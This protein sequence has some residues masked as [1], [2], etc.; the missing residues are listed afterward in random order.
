MVIQEKYNNQIRGTVGMMAASV[1][2]GLFAY[3]LVAQIW[4]KMVY[5]TLV[6]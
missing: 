1:N 3:P 5:Y 4:P 2:I 6:C